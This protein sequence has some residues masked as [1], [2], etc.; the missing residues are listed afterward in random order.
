MPSKRKKAKFQSSDFV[1]LRAIT[2]PKFAANTAHKK[3]GLHLADC[4]EIFSLSNYAS[5]F[6]TE[7]AQMTE[8][9]LGQSICTAASVTSSQNPMDKSVNALAAD[10]MKGAWS[11]MRLHPLMSSTSNLVNEDKFSKASLVKRLREDKLNSITDL[12]LFGT[13]DLPIVQLCIRGCERVIDKGIKSLFHTGRKI[14]KALLVLDGGYIPKI[15]DAT[16]FTNI[17]AAKALSDLSLRFCDEVTDAAVLTD[18]DG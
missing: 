8:S 12:A 1:P 11:P 10:I 17:S 14:C 6:N 3:P 18:A 4:V 2:A 7:P 13:G 15:A 5:K 9:I 16:I